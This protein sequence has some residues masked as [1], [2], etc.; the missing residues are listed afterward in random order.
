MYRPTE[1]C[2]T[3]CYDFA[4]LTYL[5]T[6]RRLSNLSCV[7][8]GSLHWLCSRACSSGL[9]FFFASFS[10]A[11]AIQHHVNVFNKIFITSKQLIKW[12]SI[13]IKRS[14]CSL[15]CIF[16]VLNFSTPR[17]TVS[18]LSARSKHI[19]LR[20]QKLLQNNIRFST[21]SVEERFQDFHFISH[22]LLV[23]RFA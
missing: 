6:H 1:A 22:I 17:Q 9:Q 23:L 8:A 21:L 19:S 16:Q 15:F 5:E 10:S 3:V 20:R 13:C 7:T 18:C 4:H 11:W 2:G 14:C 12:A